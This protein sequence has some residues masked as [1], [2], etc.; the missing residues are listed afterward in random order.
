MEEQAAEIMSETPAQ[1][2]ERLRQQCRAYRT[3][4]GQSRQVLR[5]RLRK[6]AL[7]G[8]A[9]GLVAA[10]AQSALGNMSGFLQGGGLAGIKLQ[11]VLPV[12]LSGVSL[13]SRKSVFKPVAKG[14][15]IAGAV[16]AGLYFFARQK[17]QTPE[18]E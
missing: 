5:S 13:L 10:R 1:Q 14:L 9:M 3:G 7:A 18:E 2:K 11:K 17:K 15:T 12:V 8:T 16:G 4:I 6:D